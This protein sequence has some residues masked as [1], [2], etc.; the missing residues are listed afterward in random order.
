[1]RALA[2]VDGRRATEKISKSVCFTYKKPLPSFVHCQK[3]EDF[4][5]VRGNDMQ[6]N[7]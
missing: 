2:M 1:M 4:K 7:Y 3:T 5:K 6:I